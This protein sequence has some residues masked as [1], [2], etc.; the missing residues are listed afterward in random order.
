M[1]S[2][3]SVYYIEYYQ[4]KANARL[5]Y[6]DVHPMP[7]VDPMY[8]D[9]HPMHTDVHSDVSRSGLVPDPMHD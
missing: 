6:T 9:V 7:D 8:T 4:F 1:R 5:G 3:G 2:V